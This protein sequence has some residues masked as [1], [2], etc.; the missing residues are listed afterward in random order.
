MRTNKEHVNPHNMSPKTGVPG[1][2]YKSALGKQSEGT[3][4][5]DQDEALL[6]SL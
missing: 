3:K 2:I 6:W 4:F 1:G 5:K